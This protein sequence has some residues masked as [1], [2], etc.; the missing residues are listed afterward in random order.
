MS[1]YIVEAVSD[2][3]LAALDRACMP[4]GW[5]QPV[6]SAVY[7]ATEPAA[8]VTWC[9]KRGLYHLPTLEL[10]ETLR[11][12]L[13]DP[14]RAIEIGAG[15][16]A[17]GKALGIRCTDNRMQEWPDIRRTYEELGQAVVTYPP[18]VEKI[19]ALDAIDKYQPRTVVAAWVTHKYHYLRH[20][21]GGNMFGVDE[22]ELLLKPSVRRY[23]FVGH[24]QTHRNKAILDQSHSVM[25]PPG[26]YSR[27]PVPG[28]VVWVWER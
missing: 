4:D 7:E 20:D 13:P 8:R 9:V 19:A 10:V 1:V 11:R 18:H 14:E 23:V 25:K 5:L 12:E 27:S 26:M 16:G 6:P 22:P 21:K 24:E 17:L 2:A 28:D 3:K 15:H